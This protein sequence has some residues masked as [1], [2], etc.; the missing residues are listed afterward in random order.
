MAGCG[1]VRGRERSER[2]GGWRTL[3]RDSQKG[4]Q[5]PEMLAA[6]TLLRE[7]SLAGTR[8]SA[9]TLAV[10]GRVKRGEKR[11]A[12]RAAECDDDDDDVMEVVEV[13]QVE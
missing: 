9:L 2:S 3:E 4:R 5:R 10:G 6:R 1:S 7:A 13:V 11:R 12:T 8:L